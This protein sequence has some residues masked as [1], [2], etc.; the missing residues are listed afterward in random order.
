MINEAV[1]EIHKDTRIEKAVI[2]RMLK[3]LGRF[4]QNSFETGTPRIWHGVMSINF[5]DRKGYTCVIDTKNCNKTLV[6]PAGRYTKIKVSNKYR[7]F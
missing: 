5:Q 6:V 3:S 7:M 2:K 1:Q 4:F